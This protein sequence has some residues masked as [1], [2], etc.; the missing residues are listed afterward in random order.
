MK[1][2]QIVEQLNI[3]KEEQD[4]VKFT[5]WSELVTVKEPIYDNFVLLGNYNFVEIIT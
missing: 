3:S 2:C 5:N 1:A 4:K